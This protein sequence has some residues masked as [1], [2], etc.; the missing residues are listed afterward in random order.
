[1]SAAES[2][3]FTS[4]MP[5]PRP[6]APPAMTMAQYGQFPDG[7]LHFAGFW[8]PQPHSVLFA[9]KYPN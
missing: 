6:M 8:S 4:A 7:S 9:R 2:F 3:Q 5:L 1:M